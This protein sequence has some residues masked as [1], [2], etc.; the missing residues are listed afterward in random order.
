MRHGVKG[1]A[2]LAQRHRLVAAFEHGSE[3][4][5][6]RRAEMAASVQHGDAGEWCS[7]SAE[8][9]VVKRR[10]EHEEGHRRRAIDADIDDADNARARSIEQRN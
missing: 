4:Q 3:L 8:R 5:R 10:V 9:D 6:R 7:V 1:A 2:Q